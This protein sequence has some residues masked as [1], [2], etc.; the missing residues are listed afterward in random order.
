M[1]SPLE[2]AHSNLPVKFLLLLGLALARLSVSEA[3]A[4]ARTGE[5]VANDLR[6]NVV[7]VTSRWTN[8]T[9][10]RSG[11]GF[12]VGE[13]NGLLYIV[14]ADHVVRDDNLAVGV[15][16]ITFYYDQGK[17]YQGDVLDT[18]LL[19]SAGDVAVVRIQPPPG[20]SWR[21]DALANAPAVRGD[22]L[23]FVG[24]QGA[25]YVTVRPGAISSIEP[26]GEIRFEGL[27]IR[28]GTSGAPLIGKSG[29]L[30][31]IVK[32]DDVFGT[33]TSVD[34]IARTFREWVYPWQL[35]SSSDRPTVTAPPQTPPSPSPPPP[36]SPSPPPPP[37]P[38]RSPSPSA[39][40]S[41]SWT[42][43]Y[44]TRDNRDIQQKDIPLPNGSIGVRNVDIDECARRC[45]S[46]SKCLAFVYDRWNRT[47]YPKSETPAS[48]LDPHS[49]IAVKK[50]G[51]IPKVLQ[52]DT[53]VALLH[54]KRMNGTLHSASRVTDS[55]ACK[56]TCNE[57]LS[58]V[59]FNFLK[60]EDRGDNCEMYKM[61]DGYSDD[62][63]V[64]AGY[65]YQ[66]P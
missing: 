42:S 37:S 28:P 55:A 64:D 15:P 16:G 5:A 3:L 13:R 56:S 43:V 30:G 45:T 62:T 21:Q 63:S 54:N 18:H 57:N 52:K 44:S 34:V 17:E 10:Q 59:A 58:C 29:I 47:C 23:W 36:P 33:A 9:P 27:A 6:R 35:T 12:L 38:S 61:S 7:R 26:G 53:L 48:I 25:W 2:R 22:D 8:G 31:M 20:L 11:F 19:K 14:T 46:N 39:S 40:P 51:E 65:K 41:P 49:M 66:S 1:G 32:D 4:Q 50:P 60:R 24:L